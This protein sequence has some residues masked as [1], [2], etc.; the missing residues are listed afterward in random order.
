MTL[1][2]SSCDC[3]LDSVSINDLELGVAVIVL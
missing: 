2:L 3:A 1:N